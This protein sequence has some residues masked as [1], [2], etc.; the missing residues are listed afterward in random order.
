MSGLASVD[1][2]G[3]FA[4]GLAETERVARLRG[5]RAILRLC[6]GDRGRAAEAELRAAEGDAGR[7]GDALAALMRLEPL[8]RRRVL[9]SYAALAR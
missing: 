7:A 8:D 1:Q 5:L 2:W 6:C 9:A 4:P 3:P